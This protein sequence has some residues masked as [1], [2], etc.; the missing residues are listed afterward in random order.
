MGNN[1]CAFGNTIYWCALRGEVDALEQHLAKNP[2]L[3]NAPEPGQVGWAPLH[4]A[5]S[6]NKPA[7]IQF[8][9]SR[10]AE[11]NMRSKGGDTSLMVAAKH[12]CPEALK[13]LIDAKADTT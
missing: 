6:G 12:G 8:L 10:G 13:V 9:L 7:A 2:A 11:L 1:C 4:A 5:A 3:I